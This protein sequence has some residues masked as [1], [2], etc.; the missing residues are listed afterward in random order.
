MPDRT[1]TVTAILRL[2]SQIDKSDEFARD[3]KRYADL[4]QDLEDHDAAAAL[5][6]MVTARRSEVTQMRSLMTR[7]ARGLAGHRSTRNDRRHATA[8]VALP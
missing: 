8:V 2:A 6:M 4:A 5:R 7:L 3:A 1:K